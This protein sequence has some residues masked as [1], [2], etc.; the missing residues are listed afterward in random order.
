MSDRRKHKRKGA[1]APKGRRPSRPKRKERQAPLLQRVAV[2]V[3]ELVTRKK[4]KSRRQ[5][6]EVLFVQ[7]ASDTI[8]GFVKRNRRILESCLI[9]AVSISLAIF[10]YSR[11]VDRGALDGFLV[12]VASATGFLLN[13][14]GGGVTV[15][16]NSVSSSA[17]AMQIVAECTAIVPMIILVSAI[18]AYPSRIRDKAIGIPVGL[19]ALFVLNLVRTFSLFHIGSAFPSFLN[20]AHFLLWQSV[21]IL[22]ALIFWILWVERLVRV[23]S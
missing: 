3:R 21:M 14:F 17:F 10:I 23:R 11:L 6:R 1:S 19:V 7:R 16:G 2:R 20:T 13:L 15:S 22:A 4:R 18:L 9:F 12:F 5:R 8:R